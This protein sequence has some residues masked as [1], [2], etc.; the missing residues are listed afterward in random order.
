MRAELRSMPILALLAMLLIARAPLACAQSAF[1]FDLPSQPLADALRAVA[2]VTHTD[3]VFDP[4]VVAGIEAPPLKGTATAR[5]ALSRLL[6]RT[7]LRCIRVGERTLRIARARAQDPATGPHSASG[8]PRGARSPR[9]AGTRVSLSVA[10]ETRHA[11]TEVATVSPASSPKAAQ[12]GE[13]VVTGT[14]IAGAMP[15]SPVI[16]FDHEAIQAS[17]Y[18][19]VGQF[20]LTVPENFNGGQNA[21]VI[22]A[23]GN[24]LGTFSG[25]ES[26]NLLGL[27]PDSTLTLIDGHRLAYDANQNNADLSLIPLAAVKSIQ[28]MTGGASAIYGSDAVAGVVNVILKQHY[29]GI[30]ADARYGDVTSGHASQAQYS[31][32]A[33]HD[34]RNGNALVAYE[35]AHDAP[36]SASDRPFSAGVDQ[37][38]DLLPELNRDSVFLG[39]HQGLSGAAVAS[40]N[41]LY[42]ARSEARVVA[43]GPQSKPFAVYADVG[44]KEFSVVPQIIV[45][46]P[47][48]W[49]LTLDGTLSGDRDQEIT[50]EFSGA[51]HLATFRVN[52]QNELRSGELGASGPLVELP[53]GPLKVAAGA[54]YR[55]EGFKYSNVSPFSASE[56]QTNA[57]RH[58]DYAYLEAD[59]P[60]VRPEA[61]RAGLERLSLNAAFRYEHYSDFGARHTPKVGIAYVPFKALVV[62]ATWSE[63]FRAPELEDVY[64]LRQLFLEPTSYLGGPSGTT[65]LLTYGANPALGPETAT[66]RV[67]SLDIRPPALPRLKI[68]PT[69]FYIHYSSRIVQPVE[70]VRNSA[71][72]PLDAPF[73]IANPTVAQ[74]AA[75][76]SGASLFTNDAGMPYDPASVAYIVND[77][78]V[79]ASVQ[80]VH[81]VDLTVEDGWHLAGGNLEL[82]ANGIWLT[83]LQRLIPAAPELRLSGTIFNPP[84]FKT[85]ETVTWRR[86]GWTVTAAY[87]YVSPEWDNSTASGA[88]IASWSTVDAQLSYDFDSASVDWLRGFKASLSIHNLFDRNPPFVAANSTT[89]PGLG[90][91]ST[92]ASPLG[93]FVSLYLEKSW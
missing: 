53:S 71:N 21:G 31:F 68:T 40:I 16:T 67:V 14:R 15:V 61:A 79:N 89:Y 6:N 39:A 38:F 87:N 86:A 13:V 51:T 3:V 80:R 7:G 49:Q 65:T 34:W 32:L 73:F 82:A 4:A 48:G 9:S 25:A 20:L 2:S 28:I 88:R 50:Q 91:D 74:Q 46:L 10:R 8:T 43:V 27:G 41:A 45:A 33:G 66:S 90:Y 47:G 29:N 17:G 75:L 35:Y 36:L 92:N 81:G 30:T 1:H 42:T 58:V 11:A 63:S 60:L 78:F 12:L 55:F 22:G 70:D 44:V 77:A 24:N 19:S 56:P 64:G 72:D 57:S 69:Y 85:R 23:R 93:R 18:G 54:G 76:I 84:K 62:R 37:P 26:A 52:Y 5:Q 83:L 59:L